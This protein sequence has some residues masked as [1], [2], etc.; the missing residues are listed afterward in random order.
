MKRYDGI[1]P[2]GLA[3]LAFIGRIELI[4]VISLSRNAC[5]EKI[6]YDD[7]F[8]SLLLLRVCLCCLKTL[9]VASLGFFHHL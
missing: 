3:C 2:F 6:N 4:S 9:S 1:R 7:H 5:G 8:I